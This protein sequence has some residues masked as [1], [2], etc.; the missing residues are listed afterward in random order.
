ML[1]G[2]GPHRF[3]AAGVAFDELRQRAAGRWKDHD[4]IGRRPAGQYLGPA[5]EP[6]RLKGVVF[7]EYDGRAAREQIVAMQAACRAGEVHT[8]ITGAGEVLGP[9]RLEHVDRTE[10]FHDAT[11]APRR[12]AYDLEFKSHDD[13]E[14]RIWSLWP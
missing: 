7:P 13:G 12:I 4:I 8:L 5:V 10:Q 14:G 2:W 9:H 11:G 3:E 1:M 6:L